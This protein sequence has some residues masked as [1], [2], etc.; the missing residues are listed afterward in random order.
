[1]SGVFMGT[2]YASFI[3][4]QIKM[5]VQRHLSTTDEHEWDKSI[6]A[7][8][9]Y[10]ARIF[11]SVGKGKTQRLGERRGARRRQGLN[12]K[13][14]G[15]RCDFGGRRR[16]IWSKRESSSVAPLPNPPL[17]LRWRREG[18]GAAGN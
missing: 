11:E 8:C 13:V 3:P 7:N 17:A 9:G 1:M 15:A 2:I 6:D 16:R 12:F 14:V 10:V 18:A 5:G 4:T